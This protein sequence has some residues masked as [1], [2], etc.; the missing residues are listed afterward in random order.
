[1]PA[2]RR[3]C[4]AASPRSSHRCSG[5]AARRPFTCAPAARRRSCCRASPRWIVLPLAGWALFG[6]PTELSVP[7]MSGFDF[8]GGKTVSPEFIAL[9]IGLSIYTA[10]FIA[11]IVRG[12]I[13]AV[14]QGADRGRAGARPVA[15]PAPAPRDAAAGAARHHPAADQP[16]P[17]PHEELV[18][19]GGDRLPRPG[20]RFQHDA[21]P[22][23]PGDRGDR[24][25][26]GRVP[27]ALARDLAA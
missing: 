21:Q 17:E 6:A 13:L 23:R 1:M 11:E 20:Q 16:I 24:S 18:A 9:F 14:P 22:D 7:V 12:G 26:D 8:E 27:D 3:R 15:R 4:S 10:A 5:R 19:R 25:D 2:G